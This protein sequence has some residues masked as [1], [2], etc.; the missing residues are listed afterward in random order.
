ML[1]KILESTL[2]MGSSSVLVMAMDLIRVK[3]CAVIL[4]PQGVGALS[5]L[6]QF[7]V[8]A[9]T[10]TSL[11]LGTGIIR[12]VAT[13][14]S[15][16]D[17]I[18]VQLLVGS[19]FRIVFIVASAAFILCFLLSPYLSHWIL[20]DKRYFVFIII[21]ALSLPLAAYPMIAGNLLGGLKK[22]KS[23]AKINIYRSIISL[24]FII[25]I[26]YFHRLKG[27]VFAVLVITSVHLILAYYY[28]TKEQR[29]FEIFRFQTFNSDLLKKLFPYGVV[30]LLTGT[31][32]YLSHLLLKMIIV[33]QLGMEMNGIYQPI[34]A[35]TMAYPALILTSM[36]AYSYPR[37]CE[38]KTDKEIVDELNGIVRIT[39]L[40]VVPTMF[41]L[42]L[43]RKP[44]I[45]MLYSDDFLAASQ[46]LPLQA[47]GDFFRVL[48]WSI[49][50]YLLPTMRLRAFIWLSIL[51][52][53][54]LIILAIVFVRSYQLHGIVTGF[55]LCYIIT[56][57]VYYWHS[58]KSISFRF[59]RKNLNLIFTSF[60]SLVA[61]VLV[62]WQFDLMLSYVINIIIILMWGCLS[63]KKEEVN[64]LKIYLYQKFAKQTARVEN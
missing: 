13:F 20:G 46:Y 63:I 26:V 4:G 56:F 34:W 22:I 61:L 8:V 44:V 48:V 42:I 17:P 21:Y 64:K 55:T 40:L 28:L 24:L 9:L 3:I 29:L 62:C 1:R 7:H 10:I 51:H 54:L 53:I 32:Y 57:L 41:L 6:N 27:A 19:A 11:G 12:Y 52:D 50:M 39:T 49:G 23:L 43:A 47:M 60:L 15:E 18:S 36:S 31:T 2:I 45:Q 5:I 38:L 35:L 33:H 16:G 37:I 59:W 30:S 58:K 25:P 14:E